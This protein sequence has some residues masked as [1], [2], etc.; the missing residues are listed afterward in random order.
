MLLFDL[1]WCERIGVDS[2]LPKQISTLRGKFCEIWKLMHFFHKN[3]C[4]IFHCVCFFA[5]LVASFWKKILTQNA[6]FILNGL[7][8]YC[9][10]Q[11]QNVEQFTSSTHLIID[12]H[13]S[14]MFSLCH[15]NY[16]KSKALNI[17][18]KCLWRFASSCKLMCE[19]CSLLINSQN[20]SLTKIMFDCVVHISY[21]FV[22]GLL[23][24]MV[25]STGTY[26]YSY[27]VC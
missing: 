2:S 26:Q 19:L 27:W 24:I 16:F 6:Q 21:T 23:S 3:V 7:M 22:S 12:I 11:Y 1:W 17:K 10:M 13:S 8:T 20:V 14:V 15:C 25:I 9:D 5:S 4:V 18:F